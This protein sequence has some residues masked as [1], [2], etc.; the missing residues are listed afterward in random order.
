MESV[1]F[2]CRVRV[3]HRRRLAAG[4]LPSSLNA[5]EFL[6]TVKKKSLDRNCGVEW[7][8][9]RLSH[10]G[11]LRMSSAEK[12]RKDEGFESDGSDPSIA[13]GSSS[14]VGSEFDENEDLVKDFRVKLADVLSCQNPAALP[15]V[16]LLTLRC[17]AEALDVLALECCADETAR[18]LTH[19]FTQLC[20]GGPEVAS[21]RA[22]MRSK[23]VRSVWNLIQRTDPGGLTHLQ[24][25]N[26][27][28]EAPPPVPVAEEKLCG[29]QRSVK[30]V[31]AA[32]PASG[33]HTKMLKKKKNSKKDVDA[34]SCIVSMQTPELPLP[35][36]SSASGNGTNRWIF[37]VT[38][39]LPPSS[40]SIISSA[41]SA[42]VQQPPGSA[43]G[44]RGRSTERKKPSR[45]DR[46]LNEELE[47]VLQ[48]QLDQ[49]RTLPA[50]LPAAPE[51]SLPA[52]PT[53]PPKMKRDHSKTRSFLMK[54]TGNKNPE[55]PE[56]VKKERGRSLL[57]LRSNART[58]SQAP[59]PLPV[60]VPVVDKSQTFLIPTK[61]G[62]E[63][64]RNIYPK[65]SPYIR[66]Q[67]HQQHPL[68]H[69]VQA[70]PMR[71]QVMTYAI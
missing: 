44:R 19:L 2:G 28:S 48:T 26:P 39:R 66:T 51:A 31:M 13:T 55:A 50:T 62:H 54:L 67:Q 6:A 45:L 59:P 30:N 29:S 1:D 35:A 33:L 43:S 20:S 34:A 15:G 56:V 65:E 68:Y 17:G 32:L 22:R 5:A 64:T 24:V 69:L 60:P 23:S 9:L 58:P 57:R 41:S 37:G 52:T 11:G 36:G 25:A 49:H 47:A 16:V 10:S 12:S 53:L 61:S 4:T 27:H 63:L 71:T 3:L 46:H 42:N 14:G 21:A 70:P 18:V 8:Q 7:T 40:A 38:P